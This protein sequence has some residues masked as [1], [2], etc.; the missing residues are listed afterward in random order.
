VSAEFIGSKRGSGISKFQVRFAHREQT[1]KLALSRLF[2]D[3]DL[4]AMIQGGGD[5]VDMV[6]IGRQ[7]G[8]EIEPL[9]P[10][11]RHAR[12]PMAE[13]ASDPDRL[14]MDALG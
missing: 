11:D 5:L 3:L 10:G 14:G 8:I 6:D 7:Q 1:G 9:A 2:V 12:R 4:N 13:M